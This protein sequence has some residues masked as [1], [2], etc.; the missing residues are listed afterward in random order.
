M[1][2]FLQKVQVGSDPWTRRFAG[3]FA[4]VYAAGRLAAEMGVAPWP[5]THPHKCIVRLYRRARELVATP[6]EALNDLLLSLA[7]NASSS[8]RF[9][10][11]KKGETPARLTKAAWGIRSKAR[12]GT[13]FVAVESNRFDKLVHPPQH[14]DRVRKLMAAGHYIVPGKEGRHVRQIKVQ[15]FGS[16]EKPYFVCVRLDR[17][18]K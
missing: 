14:A 17:L 16:T 10:E 9:P 1:G 18:P 15:G 7:N 11:F 6:E 3:K 8:H 13:P 12:D 4:V 2:K 5:K